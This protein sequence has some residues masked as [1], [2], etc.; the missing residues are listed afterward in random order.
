MTAENFTLKIQRYD[1]TSDTAFMQSYQVEVPEGM[2]ILEALL[3]IQTEQ[4][5]TLAFRYACRLWLLRY[6]HQRADRPGLQ[7]AGAGA[8]RIHDNH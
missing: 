3:R 8:W 1:P 4:D 6:G 5:G 2:T 7:D